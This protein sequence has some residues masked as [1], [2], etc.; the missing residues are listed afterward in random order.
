MT[1]AELDHQLAAIKDKV[2]VSSAVVRRAVTEDERPVRELGR[3]LF[4]ALIADDVHALC[5]AS[6]QRARDQGS[7]LRLVLRARSAPDAPPVVNSAQ[8]P[9]SATTLA[10]S[11]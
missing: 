5:V 11:R 9:S 2:L 1:P 10:R 8:E 3:R 6:R 4:E 7:T